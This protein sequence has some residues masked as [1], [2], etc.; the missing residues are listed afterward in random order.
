MAAALVLEVT[1]KDVSRAVSAVALATLS[2]ADV[3]RLGAG[4]EE[5]GCTDIVRA[6][7]TQHPGH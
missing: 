1:L 5:V 2:D 7:D 4:S 6:V 3:R